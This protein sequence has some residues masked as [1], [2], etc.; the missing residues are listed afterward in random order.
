MPSP[1]WIRVSFT[2]CVLGLLSAACSEKS[3]V[4]PGSSAVDSPGEDAPSVLV[5]SDPFLLSTVGATAVSSGSGE[6]AYVSLPTGSFPNAIS[7]TIRNVTSDAPP[8]GAVPF[9][10]GGLDPIAVPATAGDELELKITGAADATTLYRVVVPRRRPPRV[11][12]TNPPKGATDVA[13]NTRII[14]VFT[15]PISSASATVGSVRLMQGAA[16]VSGI[17][18]P[19]I[20]SLFAVEFIPDNALASG[21]SYQ[22]VVTRGILDIDGDSLETEV[23]TDFTTVA[24]GVHFTS[25]VAGWGHTCA[26]RIDDKA[27]CWGDNWYGQ[28]GGGNSLVEIGTCP[29]GNSA[30]VFLCSTAPRTVAGG[31]TFASLAAGFEHTCGLS[32]AGQALCWGDISGFPGGED[33]P[34]HCDPSTEDCGCDWSAGKCSGVPT[35]VAGG[36]AFESLVAGFWHTC[37]ISVG[38]AAYCWGHEILVGGFGTGAGLASAPSAVR[39]DIAFKSL[40]SGAHHVCGLDSSGT[41]FCWGLNLAG[42][43]GFAGVESCSGPSTSNPA[44]AWLCA[45]VPT[46]IS[47]EFRFVALTAGWQHSCGLTL[48]GKVYCWG[49]Y[50]FAG[51]YGPGP[52]PVDDNVVFTSLSSGTSA[53]HTCGVTVD[54]AVYCWGRNDFGQ[55]GDGSRTS[56][57]VAMRVSGGLAFSTVAAGD[58]HSCGITVDGQVYCWGSN[59][60]GQLGTGISSS[61]S[62]VPIAVAGR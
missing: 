57:L 34:R 35:Q 21:S 62:L 40:A 50:L 31:Q 8:V 32:A 39:G 2:A 49:D 30:R 14:T 1:R 22:L 60:A 11:V 3:P 53:S 20:G 23:T 54:N 4:A 41:A 18:Q 58:E 13:L 26:L 46:R 15:E 36:L 37:G 19:V 7:V 16:S 28:L 29:T 6:I 33:W 10:D 55:L 45:K 5:V 51:G 17:V 24:A 43:L 56:T 38:G 12:R 9:N 59:R 44:I 52:K 42:Q 61:G 48:A 25:I 27:F 47:G